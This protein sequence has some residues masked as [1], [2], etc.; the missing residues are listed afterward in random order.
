M[1]AVSIAWLAL[2]VVAA[3]G[4][5]RSVIACLIKAWAPAFSPKT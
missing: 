1:S 4:P 5:G 3:R 2:R